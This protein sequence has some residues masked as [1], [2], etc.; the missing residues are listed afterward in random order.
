MSQ[1]WKDGEI[2][3]NPDFIRAGT[4]FKVDSNGTVTITSGEIK[5]GGTEDNP[6][7][8]VDS[9]GEMH[10]KRAFIEE[11]S[12]LGNGN[13]AFL[14]GE[15]GAGFGNFG[16]TYSVYLLTATNPEKTMNINNSGDI[17]GWAIVVGTSFGVNVG[18]DGKGKMFCDN[19]KIGPLDIDS[20]KL[21]YLSSDDEVLFYID[22]NIKGVSLSISEYG[23][24]EIESTIMASGI[25]SEDFGWYTNA[26]VGNSYRAVIF[27]KEKGL[28]VEDFGPVKTLEVNYGN[29]FPGFANVTFIDTN[30]DGYAGINTYI[31][32]Q[33]RINDLIFS[34]TNY[35]II[36]SKTLQV[37]GDP[38]S[39]T[40]NTGDVFTNIYNVIVTLGGEETD[41]CPS[42]FG[43]II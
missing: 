14:I 8:S 42:V 7:F 15:D 13:S 3:I 33:V 9:D 41:Y 26:T 21:Y 37:N 12:S 31:S 24:V 27:S 43:K 40:F 6:N 34:S 5:M 17:S 19:G 11:G 16:D 39:V 2:Y 30:V 4:K 28:Y 20:E 22:P 36:Y 35:N 32:D 10:A 23:V 18:E 1:K 25:Y 38:D 29:L